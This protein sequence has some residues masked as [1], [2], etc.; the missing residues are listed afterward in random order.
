MLIAEKLILMKRKFSYLLTMML[1]FTGSC[2]WSQQLRVVQQKALQSANTGL[3]HDYVSPFNVSPELKSKSQLPVEIEESVLMQY[4]ESAVLEL[5]KRSSEFI[6]MEVPNTQGSSWTLLLKKV[7]F[8]HENY[9]I[10]T[11]VPINEE[12]ERGYFYRGKIKGQDNSLVTV[13]IFNGS[14][15]A[16]ISDDNSNY[17]LG[18]LESE[19]NLKSKNKTYIL[20]PEK[21]LDHLKKNYCSTPD[22]P[23]GVSISVDKEPSNLKS[24]ADKCVSV[25]LE[26]DYDVFQNKG[27]VQNASN[28]MT[29]V[30]NEIST[31]YANE[32]INLQ[33]GEMFVWNSPSPYG[34]FNSSAYLNGFRSERKT[35]NGDLAHL[36]SMKDQYGGVAYVDV[37]CVPSYAYG[38]SGIRS[39]YQQ[40][41]TYSWTVEVITHELG[42]NLG[43]PHT[44]SCSWQGGA[45]DD[46]YQTEGGCARGPKPT[47]G[48]T[49][50]SYCHLTSTGINFN[51]G[52]GPQPG[53]LIRQEVAGAS[54]L[55]TCGPVAPVCSVPDNVSISNVGQNGFDVAWNSVNSAVSYGFRYRAT[56][57]SSWISSNVPQNNTTVTGLVPDTEYEVQVRSNCD[58][59]NSAYSASQ[60]ITTVTDQLVYC[61][62]A[63]TSNQYEWIANV[64]VGSFSK[65]SSGSNYSDFTSDVIDITQNEATSLQLTPG[66]AGQAYNEYWSV[67]ADLNHDGDFSDAGENLYNSGAS[68]SAVSGSITIPASALL[69]ETRMRVAMRYN[70]AS[71][72]CAT[73]QYGEVEDYTLNVKADI[74]LPCDAPQALSVVATSLTD[75]MI[76]WQAAGSNETGYDVNYRA[77]GTSSWTSV[78]VSQTS[79]TLSGLQ[80]DEDYEFRVRAN[81]SSNNSAYS[82]VLSASTDPA[83]PCDN[84]SGLN[85]SSVT[86]NSATLNWGASANANSYTLQFGEVGGSLSTVQKSVTN[87][88]LSGL[89][90]STQYRFRVKANCQYGESAYSAYANFTTAA[91]PAC[92]S[93]AS[94]SSSAISFSGATVSWAAV[95]GANSYVLELR[96]AGGSFSASAVSSTSKNLSGLAAST[97]YEFRVKSVCDF[98][99]SAFSSIASFT[100]EDAPVNLNYCDA[101]GNNSSDEWIQSITVNG[102]RYNSG[103]NGGYADFTSTNIT[104][105]I[106]QNSAATFAPGFRSSL[107]GVTRYDE[108]WKVY[109]DLNRDG[110]FT[111]AGELVFDAGGVSRFDV[112]GQISIPSGVAAGETRMRVMMKYNGASTS[113]E[114][115][116]YG[117]TEDFTA[118]LVNG[119]VAPSVSG[120]DAAAGISSVSDATLAPNPTANGLST[121]RIQFAEAANTADIRV[122]D[123]TG[124]LISSE[125][126]RADAQKTAES[127]INLQDMQK[128]SY[129][130]QI[131]F[132]DNT[133]VTKQLIN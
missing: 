85:A 43:S 98:G 37:L 103:N 79:Y 49:I 110:D 14:L 124:R 71:A 25:Y 92:A 94:L 26:V 83:P 40:V 118:V 72:L 45:L 28:Y 34:G 61:D 69:G 121:L 111:D 119:F 128:G 22:L 65:S 57:A 1:L 17:N 30:F 127:K 51:N 70:Q 73:F 76:D 130:I 5:A 88:A 8:F 90:P 54:C 100:T 32:S 52:F 68:S 19:S 6:E 126:L 48:G 27:S 24:A 87:H 29:A 15:Q 74:V 2:L 35:Y 59:E 46:C 109:V 97:T 123:A 63:S 102:T 67:W 11:S 101:G 96:Q 133:Q 78:S 99:E 16:I 12:I 10:N 106:G 18:I 7:D 58:G 39:T 21:Q 64:A 104:L 23:A 62:Q 36:V 117:E 44:Q 20:F 55:G 4:D 41:P 115:Y 116:S 114:N 95:S 122:F 82:A 89:A 120:F 33:L 9:V 113:C 50:M 91:A 132:D 125:S 56:G 66:F 86:F 108:Y 75:I 42:H 131:N 47:N 105:A 112:N 107:F 13:S 38:W 77:A 53:N 81:C 93:P 3:A 80:P 60:T 84:V 31:L 129:I